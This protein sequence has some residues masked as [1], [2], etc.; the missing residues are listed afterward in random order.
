M[1]HEELQPVNTIEAESSSH[2]KAGAWNCISKPP[3]AVSHNCSYVLSDDQHDSQNAINQPILHQTSPTG[4]QY[5]STGNNSYYVY[6][7][8]NAPNL[9]LCGNPYEM[10]NFPNVDLCGGFVAIVLNCLLIIFLLFH[11][12]TT[13][14]NR[15]TNMSV[16]CSTRDQQ[17]HAKQKSK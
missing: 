8:H 12:N 16:G 10:Y 5:G 6:G 15:R 2:F 17:T 7:M 14:D 9:V 11:V 13:A 3:F 4:F 1:N